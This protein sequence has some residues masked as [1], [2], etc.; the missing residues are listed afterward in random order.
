MDKIN[1]GLF[2]QLY[3]LHGL[4]RSKNLE[5]GRDSDTGGQT[6]YVL[7]LGKALSKLPEVEMVELITRLINDKNLPD[8]YSKHIEQVDD[9]FRII[10]IQCG[11]TKYIRKELLWDHLEEFVD[12][13]IKYIKSLRKLPDVIH[14]H[15]AD[16]G[17]VCTELTKFFGI[18][19]IHTAHSLGKVKLEKLLN[20]RITQD[21]IEKQYK[22]FRRI[23]VEEEILNYADM[24]VTSTSDE[25]IAQYNKYDNVKNSKFSVI[26]PGIELEKF[27]PYNDEREWDEEAMNWRKRIREELLRFFMNINKPIILTICRPDKRKNISG[28]IKAYGED[29]QLREMANLAIFAGIRKDIQ[30]M[31]DNEKEVLTEMLLLMDK[32]DLSGYMAIPKRHDV[33]SEV[34]EFYRIAAETGGVFVNA[35]YSENFGITLIESIASGLPV[36]STNHGGPNDIIK[37]LESGILVEVEQFR[38]I[39]KAIKELLNDKDLWNRFSQNGIERIGKYYSW[40]SHVEKYMNKVYNIISKEKKHPNIF[41]EVGKKLITTDKLLVSDIDDT[42]LGDNH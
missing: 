19:F 34:P 6:K 12:K 22:I 29:I 11:G 7:E 14:S 42:L 31:P 25:I 27:Y 3:S 37:N 1:K 13:S 5:L 2:I 26:P 17:F 30:S 20:G 18:P 39:S 24:I 36:V 41:S 4:I 15:Y 38:N 33:E 21:E 9:K 40:D 32:Y 23:K 10:R 16:A 28:L 35:A 8:D